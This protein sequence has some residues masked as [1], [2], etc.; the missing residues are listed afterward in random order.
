MKIR[1][2]LVAIVVIAA[3]FNYVVPAI[4]KQLDKE[5]SC[6]HTSK[7]VVCDKQY[8]P[9]CIQYAVYVVVIV[10]YMHITPV[11]IHTSGI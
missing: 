4:G 8:I 9:L 7:G 6:V 1:H 11:Y 2:I 3:F 5:F 10:Q